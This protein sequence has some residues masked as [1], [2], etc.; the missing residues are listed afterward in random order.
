L[1]NERLDLAIV[2]DTSGSQIGNKQQVVADFVKAL[3]AEF[4]TQTVVK[5]SITAFGDYRNGQVETTLGPATFADTAT[6]Q[7]AIDQI[8]WYGETTAAAGGV[9]AGADT[10]NTNDNVNDMMIVITDGFD[11][12]LSALQDASSDAAADGIT[13]LGVAYDETPGILV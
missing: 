5:V 11:G 6:L 10:L 3:V 9:T 12:D 13:A 4:D 2:I 8:T 1:Q 7:N